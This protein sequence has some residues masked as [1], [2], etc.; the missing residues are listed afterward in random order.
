MAR[1]GKAKPGGSK[2]GGLAFKPRQ[3]K[4]EDTGARKDAADNSGA[5]ALHARTS[6]G[7][8]GG[9]PAETRLYAYVGQSAGHSQPAIFPPLEELQSRLPEFESSPGLERSPDRESEDGNSP[10]P[11]T[12]GGHGGADFE[13]L[14]L[15]EV[16]QAENTDGGLA[17]IGTKLDEIASRIGMILEQLPRSEPAEALQAQLEGFGRSLDELQGRMGSD[18]ARIA[19]VAQQILE[20]A[21][22]IGAARQGFESTARETVDSLG[23]AVVATASRAAVLAAGQVAGTLHPWGGEAS[24]NAVANELRALN[25]QSRE[26]GERTEAALDRLHVT[27]RQ[28]LERGQAAQGDLKPREPGKR[29][30]P[31]ISI[32]SNTPAYIRGNSGF[33]SGPAAEPRLDSITI[34]E[35][36]GPDPNL[37]KALEEAAARQTGGGSDSRP[38]PEQPV[39]EG[40]EP[41]RGIPISAIA[42]VAIALVLVSAAFYF[43]HSG[44]HFGPF[45]ISILEDPL[46]RAVNA[47]DAS[48]SSEALL[49]PA[50]TAGIKTAPLDT[51]VPALFTSGGES[52]PVPVLKAERVPEDLKTLEIAARAGDCDA[53]FRIGARFLSDAAFTNG[54]AVMAARWLTKAAGQ[55]HLEAQ[56]IL[57]S[58]YERGA[59]VAKDESE[60]T[61]LYRKAAAAGHIR[62]MHNLAVLLSAHDSPRDYSEAAAWFS[63]AAQ[64]G[65]PDSQFNLALL[66]ERGLGLEQ[67]LARAYL[68]YSAAARSGDKEAARQ[69]ERLKRALPA[70][71]A[72]SGP[73]S[74]QPAVEK[75]RSVEPVSGKG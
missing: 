33:G 5:P 14:L 54:G 37:V 41:D 68:W 38:S 15:T 56:F 58:L 55:G 64:A 23:Q 57:A 35:R 71:D 48:E 3:G 44:S 45:N 29:P 20:A 39:R 32:S 51:A 17:R 25:Q 74:W 30:G 53:Q 36:R 69:A 59:G 22:R 18:T 43:W 8:D 50:S 27:L 49:R 47:A 34:R 40:R 11:A 72:A 62:A 70:G 65:L 66:Y 24:H 16:V 9:P 52:H 4:R 63:R 42:I 1:K 28:Y 10:A 61:D 75:I 73:G 46:A 26:T 12:S 60:A 7:Q 21:E 6:N 2:P 67:D 13:P 31:H 19:A